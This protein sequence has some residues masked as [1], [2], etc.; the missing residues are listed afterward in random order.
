MQIDRWAVFGGPVS[1]GSLKLK[2]IIGT[3]WTGRTHIR[4]ELRRGRWTINSVFSPSHSAN[5]VP[6]PQSFSLRPLL[7]LKF[8]PYIHPPISVCTPTVGR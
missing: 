5:H 1:S 7:D 3:C 6:D 8:L 4:P 2:C